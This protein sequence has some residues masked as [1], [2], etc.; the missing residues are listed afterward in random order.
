MPDNGSDITLDALADMAGK[1]QEAVQ[2]IK[3]ACRLLLQ[4]SAEGIIHFPES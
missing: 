1:K 4:V 2:K 3:G